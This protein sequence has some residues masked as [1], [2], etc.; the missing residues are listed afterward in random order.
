MPALRTLPSATK[1][2]AESCSSTTPAV[3]P[4]PAA[5]PPVRAVAVTTATPVSLAET[6]RL[7]PAFTVAPPLV[8][9]TLPMKAWVP[10]SRVWVV[11]AMWPLTASLLSLPSRTWVVAW[12]WLE[13]PSWLPTELVPVAE[14]RVELVLLPRPLLAWPSSSEPTARTETAP[15]TP[16]APPPAPA[17]VSEVSV[18]VELAATVT[19]PFASTAAPLSMKAEVVFST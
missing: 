15:A 6:C 13:L 4:T 11:S 12:D 19:S 7:P 2:E 14:S 5:P 16:A 9:S 1:A 18:L 17:R 10:A 3:T 8:P